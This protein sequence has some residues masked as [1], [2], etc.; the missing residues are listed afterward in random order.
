MMSDLREIT[1]TINK[2]PDETSEESELYNIFKKIVDSGT[3]LRE[4]KNGNYS[5]R[6]YSENSDVL[7]GRIDIWIK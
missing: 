3:L 6:E 1:N 2:T 7:M 5:H 4:A